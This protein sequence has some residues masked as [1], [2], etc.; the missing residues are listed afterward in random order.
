ML[1]IQYINR[2]KDNIIFQYIAKIDNCTT[3][4]EMVPPTI[5]VIKALASEVLTHHYLY[6]STEQNPEEESKELVDELS[7]AVKRLEHTI[8]VQKQTSS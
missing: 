2:I 6:L 8:R 5:K 4:L 3:M 1:P 7:Q